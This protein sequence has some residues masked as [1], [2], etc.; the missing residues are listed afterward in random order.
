[1]SDP[2][3][4]SYP[5]YYYTCDRDPTSSEP[6]I[7]S[8][9][10]LFGFYWW[11]TI[12]NDFFVC[13]NDTANSLVW[14]KI[15]S[16]TNISSYL[17]GIPTSPVSILNGGTGATTAQNA[18]ANLGLKIGSNRSYSTRSSP[19]FSTPYTPSSTNDCFVMA[20]VNVVSTLVTPGT[21]LFQI[22]D[23]GSYLTRGEASV[24]GVAA[25]QFQTISAIVPVGKSYQL[26]NTSGTASIAS[27]NEISL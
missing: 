22:N 19:A 17:S 4:S 24:S 9:Y 1:M 27:I 25:S 21:V 10:S 7:F 3:L 11:N 5:Y 14:Q 23:T 18:L 13:L 2:V 12:S 15:V 16:S 26:T 6:L 8:G 20:V